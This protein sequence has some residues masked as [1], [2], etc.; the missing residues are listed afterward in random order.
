MKPHSIRLLENDNSLVDNISILYGKSTINGIYEILLVKTSIQV[1][2][3]TRDQPFD[4]A[5]NDEGLA[6]IGKALSH[7]A[8]IQI[9][10]LLLHKK[11][12]I[13]GDIVDVVGLG[14]STVSV[15]LRILKASGIITG[16][17][18]RPRVCYALNPQRLNI[19]REFLELIHDSDA[20]TTNEQAACWVAPEKSNNFSR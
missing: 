4:D 6:I 3:P 7:P 13:D 12:C 19:F 10:R 8:R 5:M 18:T 14:Q 2:C 17:I 9:I 1:P 20:E 15:H 11:T 16:E